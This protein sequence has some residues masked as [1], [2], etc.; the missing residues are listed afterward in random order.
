MIACDGTEEFSCNGLPV[1]TTMMRLQ[2]TSRSTRSRRPA[3]SL[4][5]ILVTTGI[6]GVLG[7]ALVVGSRVV[8]ASRKTASAKLQLRLIAEAADRYAEYWPK[9]KIGS[10]TI[11]DKGW[12]DAFPGR[13]F[14]TCNSTFGPFEEVMNFNDTIDLST[15]AD[16][17]AQSGHIVNSNVCL[18]YQLRASAGNG[19]FI[20]EPR[21]VNLVTS[22]TVVGVGSPAVLVPSFDT[23]CV[24][25]GGAAK[26]AE[27]FL[28][29][30]GTPLR[31][32]WVYRDAT[33][34]SHRG[35][36]PVDFAPLAN[37]S[38]A[39]GVF[40]MAFNQPAAATAT[41]VASGY[42]LESAGPDKKFGN[43]WK[44]NPSVQE[45]ADA[46]DNPV[47]MHP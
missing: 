17:I 29:P 39:Y 36:L 2:L 24:P 13:V 14:A 43:V 44:I 4:A 32:F 35:F 5:E 21:G 23:S 19:P 25:S 42:V 31:Y 11:A 26:P 20:G 22:E 7:G 45:I 3:W 33:R 16:W 10:V 6:I 1:R 30:W 9:W 15:P 38:S 28:D 18:A 47:V 46:D 12:P 40:N 41:Q 27:V 37:D 34:T 8:S